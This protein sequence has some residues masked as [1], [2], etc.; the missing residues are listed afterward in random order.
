VTSP[1]SNPVYD[2]IGVT[3]TNYR[4]PD[5]RVKGQIHRALGAASLVLNVGAGAGSYEPPGRCVGVEPSTLMLAGR[6]ADSAPVVRGVAEALPFPDGTFDAAMAVLTVHHWTDPVAGFAE[7]R[8]V[9]S[10]RI[11]VLSW[12]AQVFARFWLI[13]D[14]LPEVAAAEQRLIAADAI[15]RLLEP[16]QV[17]V[18]PVPHDC[19]DGFS[20]AYWRRPEMYLNAG[21]RQAISNLAL[22]DQTVVKRMTE[23]LARDLSS[24]AWQRHNQALLELDEL[25]CGYRLLVADPV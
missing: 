15:A 13:R 14:Y 9:T 7:V 4:K 20:A 24:G 25:D 6:P 3:Y 2:Q 1:A 17:Q 11:V 19:T 23:N 21:A 18:V 10:G 8:R 5:E 12:D 16:C 22:L